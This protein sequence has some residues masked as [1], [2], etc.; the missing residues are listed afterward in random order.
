MANPLGNGK[1]ITVEQGKRD[2][3]VTKR[4]VRFGPNVYQTSNIAGFSEGEIEMA[5]IPWLLLIILMV[6][7]LI[8]LAAAGNNNVGQVLIVLSIAGAFWNFFKPKQYG[9]LLTI[10]SGDK[11]LFSSYDKKGVRETVSA[12]SKF[13]ESEKDATYRI[14][15]NN[16]KVE[17][18]IVA[19]DKNTA[20]Y[21]KN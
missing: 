1:N 7:G 11:V 6:V 20:V 18:S 16:A 8:V 21:S 3:L 13:I 14:S 15:I 10:N 9:F 19:G 12:I 5:G 2:V 4:T 17:G